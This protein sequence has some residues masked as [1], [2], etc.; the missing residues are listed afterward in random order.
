MGT[1]SRKRKEASP[2]QKGQDY[3]IILR[4][5]EV[6][7]SPA[8]K[9][10]KED[11]SDEEITFLKKATVEMKD[12]DKMA[13][14]GAAPSFSFSDFTAYMDKTVVNRIDDLSDVVNIL[15]SLGCLDRKVGKNSGRLRKLEKKIAKLEGN[16]PG[17]TDD[18]GDNEVLSQP[19]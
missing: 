12:G 15:S 16:N 5:Q 4:K 3:S 18:E 9:R 10:K 6:S 13:G 14:K 17:V 11:S 2:I 8:L 1:G 7:A 19:R